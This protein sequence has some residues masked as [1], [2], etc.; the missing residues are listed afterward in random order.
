MTRQILRTGIP[1]LLVL[2]IG[3]CK[4]LECEQGYLLHEGGL[5][6]PYDYDPCAVDTGEDTQVDTADSGDTGDTGDTGEVVT[7]L[8]I[9]GV[10]KNT[11]NEVVTITEESVTQVGELGGVYYTEV[12]LISQYSNAETWVAAQNSED[13]SHYQG[14]W[15]R[16]D[17]TTYNEQLIYCHTVREAETEQEALDAP[18][19]DPVEYEGAVLCEGHPWS[20]LTPYEE[21]SE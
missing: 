20:T 5:C 14:L 9:K 11:Q 1:A 18:K 13:N 4:K 21:E 3:S 10:Y 15:S 16:F 19:A 6:Y 8:A 7:G 17:W 2:G 12:F